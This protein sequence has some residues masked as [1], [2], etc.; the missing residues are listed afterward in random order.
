[1]RHMET[2]KG[3]GD[4]GDLCGLS[5][6]GKHQIDQLTDLRH[7]YAAKILHADYNLVKSD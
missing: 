6:E 5:R 4:Y 7:K 2:Y 3:E 1:M